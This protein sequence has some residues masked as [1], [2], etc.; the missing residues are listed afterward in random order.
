M[1]KASMNSVE[2]DRSSFSTSNI[3]AFVLIAVLGF[4]YTLI[5]SPLIFSDEVSTPEHFLAESAEGSLINKLFWPVLGVISLG[6][7]AQNFS[8]LRTAALPSNI[9][10]LLVYVAFAGATVLWAVKP[11]VS[12]VRFVAQT[13]VITS[14][15]LPI[16]LS[17]RNTD[18]I[19]ALFLCFAVA[20]LL[21]IY[22]VFEKPIT[23]SNNPDF[24]F[25]GSFNDKNALGQ[26]AAV[27]ILI[28]LNELI[29]PRLVRRVS[30]IVLICIMFWLVL[31]SKSKTSLAL[32]LCAPFLAWLILKAGRMMRVSS[33]TILLGILGFYQVFSKVSGFNV[34]RI[35]YLVFGNPDYSGRIYIWYFVESQIAQRPLLGWGYQSFW[36]VGADGPSMAAG[37]WVAMMPHGHNG[38]LD[39]T[40]ETGYVGFYL[41]LS[42]LLATLYVIGRVAD[43]NF[44]KG[45]IYLS[46]AYFIIFDNLLESVWMRGSYMLWLVFLIVAAQAA[47]DAQFL[48]SVRARGGPGR[49]MSSPPSRGGRSRFA[50]TGVPG[51]PPGNRY[52]RLPTGR[53]CEQSS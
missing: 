30:G 13:M 9:I 4:I 48:Q 3:D 49:P 45:W 15:V 33:A 2:K 47:R 6:F 36:L 10:C 41:L 25:Q 28:A 35:S 26:F 52:S 17:G 20:T 40:L 50:L 43:H 53:D 18:T 44:G 51:R 14:T 37:G 22:S 32:A 16:L 12:F 39:V 21:S 24:G 11:D 1:P 23:R 38:Y 5:V 8:R 27:G 34:N 7:A 19:H 29:S 42:F 46:L 31:V